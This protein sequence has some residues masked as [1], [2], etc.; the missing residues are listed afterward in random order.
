MLRILCIPSLH[1]DTSPASGHLTQ[2]VPPPGCR[3]ELWSKARHL[4]VL[5][6]QSSD[7]F[8]HSVFVDEDSALS[9][10]PLD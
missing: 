1:G 7:R 10:G 3:W 2:P 8:S 9:P 6:A 4:G 5:N